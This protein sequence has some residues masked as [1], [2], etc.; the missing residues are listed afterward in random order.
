MD[1]PPAPGPHS[2]HHIIFHD[3]K[4]DLEIMTKWLKDSGKK[5][6]EGKT[7][8]CVF[9]KMHTSQISSTLNISK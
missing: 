5:A 3:M 4:K 9:H 6:Y 1:I 8:M 7:E 2:N